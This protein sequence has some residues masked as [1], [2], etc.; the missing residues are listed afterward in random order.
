MM[1]CCP[2]ELLGRCPPSVQDRPRLYPNIDYPRYLQNKFGEIHSVF[3]KPRDTLISM[4]TFNL[5]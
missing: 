2:I 1:S 3:H 5:K 4:Q